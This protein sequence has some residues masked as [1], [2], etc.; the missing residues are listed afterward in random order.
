[1]LA[2]QSYEQ[3]NGFS[4]MSADELF[5]VNGGSGSSGNALANSGSSSKPSFREVISQA[6]QDY[7]KYCSWKYYPECNGWYY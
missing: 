6:L 7:V 2:L 1:M 4:A 3:A 5:Y